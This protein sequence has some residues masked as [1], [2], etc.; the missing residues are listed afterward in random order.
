[1]TK[2]RSNPWAVLLVLNMGFFMILLDTTIVNIAIPSI[3]SSLGASLDEVLWILNSYIL[4]YAALL[5]T[6]GRLGDLYGQRNMFALGMALFVLASAYSGQ[7]HGTSQ[8]IAGRVLQG[9]GGAM[10][11][12]QTMAIITTIFPPERRGAAFGIWGSVAGIAAVTGPTLG[13]FIVT[14][15]DW[16]WIFYVNLP[17]G[18]VAF[19][20]TFLIVPDIRPGRRHSLD[21]MGVFLTTMGLLAIVFGLVEG[22][23]FDWG[24]VWG[25]IT[26]PEIIGAGV[27]VLIAFALW[28][29]RQEEPL[30][31][32]SL[33]ADR[34]Y[35]AMNWIAAAVAFGMLGLFFPITIYLQ[36][37]LGMSALQAGL[38]MAPLSLAALVV[39]PFAGRL[40]DRVGGKY[41]LMV[42][43]LLYALGM[44]LVAYTA[45]TESSWSTFLLPLLLAGVGQGCVFA[46]MTTVAMRDISPRMAGAAS[47]VLN[48]T[49][50]IGAVVG[51]ALVGAVL[52][53]Q[54]VVAMRDRAIAD[55]AQLPPVVQ[56]PFIEAFS[57][58][59]TRGL[60]VGPGQQGG[61]VLPPGLPSQVAEQAARLAQDVFA[62][63]FVAAM[64]PALMVPIAVLVLGAAS[65]L[66]VRN[67]PAPAWQEDQPHRGEMAVARERVRPDR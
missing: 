56:Q 25:S 13:G 32:F 41:V 9:I 43:L 4:V 6:A 22:Q 14:H 51:S 42:G 65:T 20:A 2:V 62:H 67:R 50:Q 10:L 28:E 18:I 34:N 36:S 60:E 53:N 19:I 59:G 17:I 52:Q 35:L 29:S 63:G 33:F 39:A 54:L 1:M 37:V 27:I 40:T 23:R 47:G 11:T 55:S 66:I 38:T 49:R 46:P 57:Q 45:G 5:I 26:I 61:M 12:P 30:V 21:I 64:H 58:V 16:R 31:P 15:Q 44:G 24:V 8:L 48:T 7:A 3:I